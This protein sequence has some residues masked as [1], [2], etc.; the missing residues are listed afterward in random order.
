MDGS[1]I[2]EAVLCHAISLYLVDLPWH[3]GLVNVDVDIK[4]LRVLG[5]GVDLVFEL[6]DHFSGSLD[7][8]LVLICFIFALFITICIVH[9]HANI[10][11]SVRRSNSPVLISEVVIFQSSVQLPELSIL[12]GAVLLIPCK[13]VSASA[14]HMILEPVLDLALVSY[15]DILVSKLMDDSIAAF[16]V[17]LLNLEVLVAVKVHPVVLFVC[18]LGIVVVAIVDFVGPPAHL[19]ST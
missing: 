13:R 16:F 5:V 14:P 15:N 11:V 3:N 1:D 10:N 8:I 12:K 2:N 4:V 17:M 9:R 6:L 7:H 18:S 19:L